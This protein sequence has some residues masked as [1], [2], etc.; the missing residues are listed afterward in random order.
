V[1]TC[2]RRWFPTFGGTLRFHLQGGE[3]PE[4]HDLHVYD[5]ED[6]R[7]Q[8]GV[9]SRSG[10]CRQSCGCCQDAVTMELYLNG[11]LIAVCGPDY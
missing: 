10:S 8:A 3:N 7:S 11:C 2:D 6:S 5:L 1:T 4:D 9:S